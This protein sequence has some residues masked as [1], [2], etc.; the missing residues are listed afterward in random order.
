MPRGIGKE[1]SNALF[2]S[3][4]FDKTPLS[5]AGIQPGDLVLAIDDHIMENLN[6]F[7]KYID[8]SS[9]G[10][11]LLLSVYRDGGTLDLPASDWSGNLSTLACLYD[12]VETGN[13]DRSYSES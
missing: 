4:V 5:R 13:I 3:R 10:E 9:P 12:W 6:D 8:T 2:V 7:R 11:M 1:Q